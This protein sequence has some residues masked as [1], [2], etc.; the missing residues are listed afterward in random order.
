MVSKNTGHRTWGTLTVQPRLH[1]SAGVSQ[2]FV[3]TASGARKG[4]GH[5]ILGAVLPE[6]KDEPKSISLKEHSLVEL[7]GGEVDI[8]STIYFGKLERRAHPLS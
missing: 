8:G 1:I 2:F 7:R 3:K 6:K 4:K 5:C